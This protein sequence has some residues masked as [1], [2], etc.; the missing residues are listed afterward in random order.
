MI[1]REKEPEGF[2]EFWREWLPHCRKTDG[3][4]KARPAYQ[5]MIDAGFEAQDII[6]GCRWYLRNMSERDA[7]YI[8]LAASW[9]R[10]ERFVDDC[11]SERAFQQRKQ[12]RPNIVPIRQA[13]KPAFL[14]EFERRKAAEE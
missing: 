5:Q 4:G 1:Q 11:T 7:P 2:E 9:L 8:P 12:E 14:V 13:P 10:S 6:D 3:R